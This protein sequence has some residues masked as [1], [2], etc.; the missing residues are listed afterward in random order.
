MLK[1]LA[2]TYQYAGGIYNGKAEK[3]SG[4]YTLQRKY[5][6]MTYTGLF[7]EKGEQT[8]IY[9]KGNYRLAQDTCFETQTYSSQPSKVT[10]VTL[11]YQYQLRHDTLSLKGGLPNGTTV[12]EYWK[13]VNGN[14]L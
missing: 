10:G 14:P 2:G 5:D 8:L 12:L 9:E 4:G 7:I 3:P 13:K 6:K 11:H 1:A